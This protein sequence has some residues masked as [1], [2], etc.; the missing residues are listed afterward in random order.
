PVATLVPTLQALIVKTTSPPG[1]AQS[2]SSVTV[3][4][5]STFLMS[6]IGTVSAAVLSAGL[7]SA[8][9]VASSCTATVVSMVTTPGGTAAASRT[10][11]VRVTQ[12]PTASEGMVG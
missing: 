4:V 1:E 9:C 11:K 2:M 8:P 6:Q 7:A 10:V 5:R 3:M 12:A